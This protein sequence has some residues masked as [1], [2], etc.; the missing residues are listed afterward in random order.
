[1]Y[2]W[3]RGVKVV[4]CANCQEGGRTVSRGW[5]WRTPST[6][7]TVAVSL[8][9]CGLA[10]ISGG[11]RLKQSVSLAGL[12]FQSGSECLQST[13]LTVQNDSTSRLEYLAIPDGDYIIK[14]ATMK[15]GCGEET[16]RKSIA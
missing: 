6:E 3:G 14:A 10:A 7:V 11:P 4:D 1:M 15:E 16:T 8:L 9:K 2:G 13:T 12:H 5:S